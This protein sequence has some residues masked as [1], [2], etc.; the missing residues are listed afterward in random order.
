[1]CELNFSELPFDALVAERQLSVCSTT[2]F[3]TISPNPSTK[4]ECILTGANRK[5]RTVKRP[6]G[7]MRQ[8][9]QYKYCLQCFQ[10]DYF[11]WLSD[12]VELCGVAE[13]N[14]NGNVHLHILINDPHI[15]NDVQMQVFRRDVLNGYRTQ[16]NIIKGKVNAK[17]WMNNIV[18][19]TKSK[20]DIVSYFMKD[21]Q[22]MLPRFKNFFL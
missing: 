15:Y 1:M 5:S 3:V 11:E 4:I 14:E 7:T 2:M 17:D 20:V 9:H 6:Y 18:F 8:D 16:Q 22:L 13:L 21:Q 19:L 12:D 10:E